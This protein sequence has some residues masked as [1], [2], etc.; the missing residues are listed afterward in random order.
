MKR[1]DRKKRYTSDEKE[2]VLLEKKRLEEDLNIDLSKCPKCGEDVPPDLN[3]CPSCG[4]YFSKSPEKAAKSPPRKRTV[5]KRTAVEEAVEEERPAAEEE[6]RAEDEPE[7]EDI[8]SEEELIRSELELGKGATATSGGR[9]ISV[10]V[11][12]L[13]VI[14]YLISPVLITN[15]SLIAVFMIVGAEIIVIGGNMAYTSFSKPAA[16]VEKVKIAT[17]EL[18]EEADLDI[19]EE[20]EQ[21]DAVIFDEEAEELVRVVEEVEDIDRTPSAPKEG[22]KAAIG[23]I[24]KCPVCKS[25][26]ASDAN[27]CPNCGTWFISE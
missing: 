25:N 19:A 6:R 26:I 15:Y 11:I 17:E 4:F 23:E 8:E 27:E 12:L 3:K 7:E 16:R 1:K 14:S 10:V 9:T 20:P 24:F 21:D 22:E 13:G 2:D 18:E 5:H